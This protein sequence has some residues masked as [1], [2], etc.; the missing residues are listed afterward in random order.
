MLRQAM[1]KPTDEDQAE[2]LFSAI[3]GAVFGG[4]SGYCLEAGYLS[5][6]SS[7]HS[8]SVGWFIVFGLFVAS[9]IRL[10]SF[11]A[12][13]DE[14]E[15]CNHLKGA[16]PKWGHDCLNIAE[17]RGPQERQTAEHQVRPFGDIK[18]AMV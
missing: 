10:P 8:L 15:R 14:D 9:A 2:L 17:L 11:C 16:L 6:H 4:V 5:G 18:I 3:A 1:I 7:S 13:R 12:E